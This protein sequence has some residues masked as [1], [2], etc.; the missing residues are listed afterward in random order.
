MYAL[1]TVFL[2]TKKIPLAISLSALGQTPLSSCRMTKRLTFEKSLP[3]PEG[4]R[5][6]QR[7]DGLLP[8]VRESQQQSHFF[9]L[10]PFQGCRSTWIF[11]SC[12]CNMSVHPDFHPVS[13]A[14]V[15][16]LSL[17]PLPGSPLRVMELSRPKELVD[18][19]KT[20]NGPFTRRVPI[21][22]WVCVFLRVPSFFEGTARNDI[23]LDTILLWDS[24]I[25]THKHTRPN[26]AWARFFGWTT[27]CP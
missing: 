22:P 25:P 12:F 20:S 21:K 14:G 26:N 9:F 5:H 8:P 2:N 19:R 6:C 4:R 7:V 18:A 3:A 15:V 27:P 17:S 10:N 1:Q 13:Q 16:H 11:N 23:I 24:P